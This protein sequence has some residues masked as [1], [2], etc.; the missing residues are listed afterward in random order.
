MAE[1]W[2]VDGSVMIHLPE[3]LRQ[4]SNVAG[5]PSRLVFREHL[6]LQRFGR[7]VARVD[8]RERSVSMR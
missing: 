3:Q 1:P 8:V 5:D 6:R 2:I 7:V 4:P